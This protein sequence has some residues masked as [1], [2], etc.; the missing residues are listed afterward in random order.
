MI[1]EVSGILG[2]A[3]GRTMTSIL[4]SG[5]IFEC[6]TRKGAYQ[7]FCNTKRAFAKLFSF[8][9]LCLDN[10]RDAISDNIGI[11]G[12]YGGAGFNITWWWDW[13]VSI[14]MTM[15]K[16]S[17][18]CIDSQN[19]RNNPEPSQDGKI[20]PRITVKVHKA[21]A[22]ISQATAASGSHQAVEIE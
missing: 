5:R 9:R 1:E 19:D 7:V 16:L 15:V 6:I 8:L 18:V 13:M 11:V 17:L 21:A 14:I 12:G 10:G 22:I 3:S 20:N 4:R 2:D